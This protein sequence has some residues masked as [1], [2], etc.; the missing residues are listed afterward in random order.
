MRTRIALWIA[1][2]GLVS[3]AV[4]ADDAPPVALTLDKAVQLAL[5]R[6]ERAGIAELDVAV[7]DASVAKARVAF[8]PVLGVTGNDTVKPRDKP[9]DVAQAQLSLNQPLLDLPAIPLYD[10][11]KHL[12]EGQ[13][14]QSTDDKRLLAFDAARAYV[15]VLLEQ[16]VVIAAEKKLQTAKADVD[17]TQAQFKAQ[18]VSSNDVTRAQISLAGSERE[19]ANDRGNLEQA[20]VQLEL[21][22]NA[23]V[24]RQLAAPSALLAASEKAIAPP[25][26]LVQT[27]LSHRPDLAARKDSALAAHDFAREPRMRYYP[28]LSLTGQLSDTSNTPMNGHALDGSIA[29][30]ASWSIYDAGS[31]E[32]DA[33]SRDA[34]AA[35]ADLN[36]TALARSVDAQV[37]GAVA[38]LAAAQQ[39]LGG[40][41]DAMLASQKSADETAI[42][43]RQGLARAIELVD[44]NDQRFEAEVSYAEAE[45]D[46]ASAYLAL[47]QALGD[48]PLQEVP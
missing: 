28:T 42:L 1:G 39:A 25:D 45:F 12:L 8:L 41:H 6:N 37:R 11:A 36:T 33:R 23:K 18:L 44:A 7:A 5:T 19:L 30:S 15:T 27:A 10:E 16:Q 29:L 22:V 26:Q 2:I 21:L 14:A 9:T 43:Y 40:A 48:G 4:F 20:F 17:D 31:R 35:I 13:R 24:A 46:V 47:L 32:A 3:A 38:Q 34:Q